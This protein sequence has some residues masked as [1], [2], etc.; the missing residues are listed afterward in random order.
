MQHVLERER[1]MLGLHQKC[2]LWRERDELGTEAW[3]V[4]KFITKMDIIQKARSNTRSSAGIIINDRIAAWSAYRMFQYRCE[5][6]I[7]GRALDDIALLETESGSHST[8]DAILR[9]K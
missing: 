8:L 3:N 4:E 7:V 1:E 6:D 5:Y 9:I 2:E